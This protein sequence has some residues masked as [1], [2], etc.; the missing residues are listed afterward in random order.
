MFSSTSTNCKARAQRN[1]R[2]LQND[3]VPLDVY[4]RKT[5]QARYFAACDAGCAHKDYAP[6]AKL[7]AEWEAA[8]LTR[9]ESLHA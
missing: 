2:C 5:D 9:W 6:L 3:R 4:D 7:V 8:A 1:G